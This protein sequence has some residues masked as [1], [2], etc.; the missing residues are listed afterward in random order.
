[1]TTLG[2]EIL[3]RLRAQDPRLVEAPPPKWLAAARWKPEI[4]LKVASDKRLLAVDVI[5]S[6]AVPWSIYRHEVSRILR[7]HRNLRVVVCVLEEGLA[8]HPEI[9]DDCRQACLG[10]KVLLPGLGIETEV[11]TDLDP[12]P[13]ARTLPTEEGWFPSAILAAAS[14]VK[15]L[16]FVGEIH[17]FLGDLDA[18]RHDRRAAFNLVCSTIDTML[19][20]HPTFSPSIRQFMRLSHFETLLELTSPG[21][22]EHVLH[23]FRVF[24]AGCPIIDRFYGVFR[25]AHERFCLGRASD[26]SVEYTWLLASIFH[27]IGRP[28]EGV[29]RL[30]QDELQDEDEEVTVSVKDTHWLRPQCQA[31]RRTLASLGAFVANLPTSGDWDGGT[32]PDT[33]ADDLGAALTRLYSGVPRGEAVTASTELMLRSHAVVGSMDFLAELFRTAAA[34]DQTAHRPFVVTHAVPAALAILLHDWRIWQ[35]ARTWGLFPINF[36]AMPMAALLIYLDTWDDYRRTGPDAMIY[37]REYVVDAGGARVTIEWA[38]GDAFDR[39][40]LKYRAFKSAL[41][42]RP[43][44][45]QILPRM[46]SP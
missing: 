8:R 46:A 6:A 3:R 10:L 39:E 32:V 30:V 23:S 34:A 14:E 35:D 13:P 33:Q 28:K 29:V 9:R 36:P 25:S 37:V 1:V 26:L 45:L 31:A 16:S 7:S 38:D 19:A 21:S 12:T 43:F 41:K 40:K 20:Q 15:K 5:P 22:T 18:A 27:D 44:R 24:L 17:R 11:K 2:R 42:G 4:V